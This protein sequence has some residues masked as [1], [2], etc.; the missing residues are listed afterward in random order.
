MMDD[1]T[2]IVHANEIRDNF[3]NIKSLDFLLIYFLKNNVAAMETVFDKSLIPRQP[4]LIEKKHSARPIF[5]PLLQII[6][7]KYNALQI[8]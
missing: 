1:L 4:H 5:L 6:T 7:S 8:R 3:E 2:C